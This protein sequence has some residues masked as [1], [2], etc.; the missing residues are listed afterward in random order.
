MRYF[1]HFNILSI[2][3][4]WSAQFDRFVYFVQNILLANKDQED[5][6]A[7]EKVA[8]VNN[9]EEDLKAA[10]VLITGSIPVVTMEEIMET[11]EGPED[12]EN[13]EQLAE[14]DLETQE[15][16]DNLK[17]VLALA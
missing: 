1:C 8:A 14:E 6:E 2:N 13:R 10:W 4:T 12:A 17:C 9:S 16:I 15:N 11:R 3:L 7:S 5:E